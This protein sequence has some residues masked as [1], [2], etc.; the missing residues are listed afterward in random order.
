MVVGDG[1]EPSKGRAQLIYSQSPLATWVTY[2]E[3]AGKLGNDVGFAK[4]FLGGISAG[5]RSPPLGRWGE[6]SDLGPWGGPEVASAVASV[7]APRDGAGA[8]SFSGLVGGRQGGRLLPA[9]APGDTPP[10]AASGI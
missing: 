2:R 9:R 10:E 6:G 1:F 7:R 5:V 4:R 3:G 8:V